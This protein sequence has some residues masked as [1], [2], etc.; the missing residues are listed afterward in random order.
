MRDV[1]CAGAGFSADSGLAVYDDVAKA[2]W[3]DV[4]ELPWQLDMW[5]VC[6]WVS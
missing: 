4:I 1:Q 2:G 3:V 6:V 5:H